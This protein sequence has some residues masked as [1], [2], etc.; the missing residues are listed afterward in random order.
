MANTKKYHYYVMVFTEE[1]PKYVTGIGEH[2]TAE[3]NMLEKP[4]EMSSSFAEDVYTG[5]CWNF[6]TAI[7]V[8]SRFEIES[9]PYRYNEYKINFE[10]REV[11]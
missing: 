8:K 11:E 9:Q 3:W 7:L 6:H 5:L 1:G 4:L 2:H 10:K